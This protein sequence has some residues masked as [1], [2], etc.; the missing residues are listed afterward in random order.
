MFVL[1]FTL[2]LQSKPKA[3]ALTAFSNIDDAWE[4]ME[5]KY[6]IVLGTDKAIEKGFGWHYM[7]CPACTLEVELD[8]FE[9]FAPDGFVDFRFF[10]E[11][12]CF[13]KNCHEQIL[14]PLPGFKIKIQVE[15]TSDLILLILCHCS[16]FSDY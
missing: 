9:V 1:L 13:N 4:I 8:T 2:I 12:V 15:D 5:P 16:G 3:F 14:E 6:V 7:W 11:Y 10:D